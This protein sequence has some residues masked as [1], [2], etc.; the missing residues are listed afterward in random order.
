MGGSRE[1]SAFRKAVREAQKV[2]AGNCPKGRVQVTGT[3]LIVRVDGLKTP[4]SARMV[5]EAGRI[6]QR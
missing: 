4:G 5:S 6:A 1:I 2:Q 3:I